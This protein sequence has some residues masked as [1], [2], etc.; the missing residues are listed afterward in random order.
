MRAGPIYALLATLGTF[1]GSMRLWWM[2]TPRIESHYL[3]DLLRYS[4]NIPSWKGWPYRIETVHHIPIQHLSEAVYQGRNLAEV[5]IWPLVA[6]GIVFML[7]IAAVALLSDDSHQAN[8]GTVLRGPRVITN[9]KWWLRG[10]GKKK[11]FYIQQ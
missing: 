8:T 1:A 2:C 6:T 10:M 3:P 7:S 5:L 9:F 4:L 11:G